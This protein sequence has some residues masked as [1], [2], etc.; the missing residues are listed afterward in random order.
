MAN[1]NNINNI[2]RQRLPCNHENNMPEPF[3]CNIVIDLIVEALKNNF[4]IDKEQ[5]LHYLGRLFP[6][7]NY[8]YR[9]PSCTINNIL[10]VKELLN[11][12]F[13]YMPTLFADFYEDG[14]CLLYSMLRYPI[15][16]IC[17]ENL[18][19]LNLSESTLNFNAFIYAFKYRL[20]SNYVENNDIFAD[21]IIKNVEMSNNVVVELSLF[22]SDLL[23]EYIANII[24]KSNDEYALGD[25]LANAILNLPYSKP[26]IYALS[27]QNV[28]ITNDDVGTVLS[29]EQLTLLSSY[30]MYPIC[31][32]PNNISE[33]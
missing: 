11:A 31:N 28:K 13:T 7:Y 10:K 26:I 8:H 29:M 19:N 16:D 6:N 30:S 24:D 3:H 18:N 5:L 32:Q 27:R 33:I 1:I 17:F 25:I 14:Y 23:A 4:L 20:T 15:Y 2:L 9:S 22:K 21:F 12:I